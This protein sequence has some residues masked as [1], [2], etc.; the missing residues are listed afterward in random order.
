MGGA[1]NRIDSSLGKLKL[2]TCVTVASGTFGLDY[3]ELRDDAGQILLPQQ[4]LGAYVSKTITYEPKKGNPTPRLYETSCG[5]LN[6]IGLQNPGLH[7]FLEHDLPILKKSL[8]IPLIVSFSAS[9]IDQFCLMLEAME[10]HE[11]IAAY[12]VNVSCPNVEKEG[13]AFGAE[14][15]IIHT[16]VSRLAEITKKELIVKLSP[17]VTDIAQIALAAQ[18]AGAT[19]L[20]LINTLWGMAI[21]WKTG[22]AKLSKKV[23]GY[24]GPG[25]KP[26]ALAL[27][28]KVAQVIKI[29]ILA[30][31]GIR[32]WQDAIEFFYAGASAI[33]IGTANFSDPGSPAKIANGLQKFCEEKGIHLRDLIGK[34]S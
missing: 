16:L 25:V 6:S 23:G 9:S 21:D 7:A 10:A 20:A 19:S 15:E 5:L 26:V 1:V 12:E 30:M 33:A 8:Q 31:G 11:G 24:S 34:V 3:L 22:K 14:A 29:P 17:N 13:I 2:E 32:S 28:Y 4:S 27:V 18:E